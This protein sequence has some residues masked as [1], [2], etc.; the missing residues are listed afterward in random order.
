MWRTKEYRRLL[1][2]LPRFR[3]LGPVLL[4]P[5]RPSLGDFRELQRGVPPERRRG[6]QGKKLGQKRPGLVYCQ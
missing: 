1:A 2:V 6:V 5:R 3:L 4:P